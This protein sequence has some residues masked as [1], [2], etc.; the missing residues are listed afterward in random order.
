MV[1]RQTDISNIFDGVRLIQQTIST[2]ELLLA[3]NKEKGELSTR[4]ASQEVALMDL[5]EVINEVEQAE[6]KTLAEAVE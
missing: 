6:L 5:Q 1:L 2:C 3:E 4:A